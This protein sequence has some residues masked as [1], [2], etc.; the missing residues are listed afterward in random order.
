MNLETGDKNMLEERLKNISES[1][2]LID[3]KEK[4]LPEEFII[5]K[6]DILR[7]LYDTSMRKDIRKKI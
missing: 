6:Q 1:Y 2:E 7:A 3:D 4:Y 5:S